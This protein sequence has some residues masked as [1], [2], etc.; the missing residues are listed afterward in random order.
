MVLKRNSI[1]E[2][3]AIKFTEFGSITIRCQCEL[4]DKGK[5]AL[6]FEIKVAKPFK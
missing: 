2:P 4:Q 1:T 6:V 5:V 3:I